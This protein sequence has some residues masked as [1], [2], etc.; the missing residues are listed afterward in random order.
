MGWDAVAGHGLV[1]EFLRRAIASGRLAHALAFIGPAGV[2]KAT[3]ARVLAQALL[4]RAEGERPCG[5]CGA[6]RRVA[7]GVHPDVHWVEPE[8]GSV[9]IEQVRNLQAALALKAF[10]GPVKFAAIDGA[11]RMTPEAQNCL[12][13]VLEE[14]PGET[15]I[16]LVAES[17]AALLPTIRSRCQVL[18]FQPLPAGDVAALLAAR[19]VDPE[20]ARVI[21]AVTEGRPGAALAAVESDLLELRDRVAGWVESLLPPDGPRGVIHIGQSLEEGREK[22]EEA[23]NLFL[24]WLKDLVAVREGVPAAVANQD[25]MDRLSRQ[26][27]RTETSR[28]AAAMR[29]VDLAR[30]RLRASGNFRLTLDAMLADVQRSLAS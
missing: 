29:A 6:C 25:A 3:L 21:A 23:L 28:L 12:L 5:E 16:T 24:L 26:A 13:K 15:V 18:R 2:G 17:G 10:E 27:S 19:G 8:G 9:R 11:D 22:A 20:R 7:K 30:R 14:P 4:C 1:K